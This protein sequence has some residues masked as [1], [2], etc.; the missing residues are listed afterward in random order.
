M[1]MV[2]LSVMEPHQIVAETL[3]TNDTWFAQLR[4]GLDG[5]KR[6][7]RILRVRPGI[8]G[9]A[10][11]CDLTLEELGKTQ[12]FD[13]L[14]YCCGPQILSRTITVNGRA[15]FRIT[16][17]LWNA[18]QRVRRPNVDRRL[19]VDAVCIDQEN[20][21][22]KSSQIRH[23]HVVYSRA[24]EV[25][26]Y[27]GECSKHTM[28]LGK[29]LEHT[30]GAEGVRLNLNHDLEQAE[31]HWDFAAGT[32]PQSTCDP[33]ASTPRLP[34]TFLD[35]YSFAKAVEADLSRY[36][37]KDNSER[38][39]WWKR[40]WTVQELLLAKR[41]VVYLGPYT[42]PWAR[43]CKM[44]TFV[45]ELEYN[46]VHMINGSKMRKEIQYLDRLRVDARRSLHALL[47]ATADKGY[48]EP[49]DRI[50]ALLG[51]LPQDSLTLDYTLGMR[52]ISMSAAVHCMTTQGNFDIL[53]SH[54][55]R[56]LRLHD[57]AA[58]AYSC[59]PN[60]DR[61][62]IGN[63]S[64]GSPCL[65]RL[66]NGRWESAR[67]ATLPNLSGYDAADADRNDGIAL[68]T[69]RPISVRVIENQST[70][71]RIAFRG[72]F[73]TTISKLYRLGQHGIKEMIT[74]L[75]NASSRYFSQPPHVMHEHWNVPSAN[76]REQHAYALYTM[77]SESCLLH[78]D[79]L[80]HD[81]RFLDMKF[82]A[83]RQRD[84]LWNPREIILSPKEC[85]AFL[86]LVDECMRRPWESCLRGPL[87]LSHPHWT[88]NADSP[89]V[90]NMHIVLETLLSSVMERKSWSGN[91]FVTTDGHLGIGPES[92]R[93]G[94]RIA[95]F[96]GAR[97]PFIVR[98]LQNHDYA[99]LG[100]SFVLGLMHGEVRDLD[101]RGGLD[102][103]DIVLQ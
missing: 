42:M 45:D 69:G 56:N 13:A 43:A 32:L 44:W 51:A 28:Y 15:G 68:L 63:M 77:L 14:S 96:D 25:C 30:A 79:T 58:G 80:T 20:Y 8:F 18:F 39:F 72:A 93:A 33:A 12:P 50:F 27:F 88:A 70:R 97:S 92:T 64:H 52:V 31:R 5:D 3:Y 85:L 98:S 40:L 90:S 94:D 89:I 55:E 103:V 26:I 6:W 91:F 34:A 17:N 23:L 81:D 75:S 74:Y 54:W 101:A 11:H 62:L 16:E 19:W 22:E 35:E 36:S 60:F 24:E 76:R 37:Q 73:A 49:K 48:T 59:L 87:G 7:V 67:V 57:G 65:Q 99:L 71:C 21:R 1:R 10:L 95:I 83:Q 47:L 53:F 46:K 2:A 82:E 100:D 86:D 38:N 29:C 84:R 66:E 4:L 102:F 78:F 41:P 9:A 61:K